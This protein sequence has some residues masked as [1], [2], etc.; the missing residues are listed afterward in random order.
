MADTGALTISAGLDHHNLEKSL[1]IIARELRSLANTPVGQTEMRRARD[2]VT[3]QMELSLEGTESQMNWLG[4]SILAYGKIV[5]PAEAR[6]RLATVTAG[7]VRAAARD[8]FRPG[9]LNLALISPLEKAAH[10]GELLAW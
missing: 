6:D 1:R 4:E 9:R 10:L 7:S 2:Y 5:T 8:F 3:G